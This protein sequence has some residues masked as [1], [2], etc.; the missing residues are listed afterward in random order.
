MNNLL[1]TILLN[2]V[3]GVP[4]SLVCV[5]HCNALTEYFYGEKCLIRGTLWN[6]DKILKD[7]DQIY[8]AVN[9]VI[10]PDTQSNLFL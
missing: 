2:D 6:A 4:R 10:L 5:Q 3:Y 1:S 7:H 8:K 9:S